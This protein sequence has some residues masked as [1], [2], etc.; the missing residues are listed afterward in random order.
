MLR[1]SG[2][3]QRQLLKCTDDVIYGSLQRLQKQID[4]FESAWKDVQNAYASLSATV[5]KSEELV[6]QLNNSTTALRAAAQQVREYLD[7]STKKKTPLAEMA[8]LHFGSLM[9][10]IPQLL[11][12][13]RANN[14][15]QAWKSM[16]NA[17]VGFWDRIL[18][19]DRLKDLYRTIRDDFEAYTGA[20]TGQ[21]RLKY[22]KVLFSLLEDQT[23][24]HQPIKTPQDLMELTESDLRV[25]LNAEVSTLSADTMRAYIHGNFTKY[26]QD[27]DLVRWL[28]QL[29]VELMKSVDDFRKDMEC[30]LLGNEIS[31]DFYR[32]VHSSGKQH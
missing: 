31:A 24:V 5:K 25:R 1:Q 14:N 28:G 4:D 2:D 20:R 12:D 30:F 27:C 7:H 19:D 11:R 17:A 23:G 16:E 9:K 21:E 18:Q 22:A 3:Y 29:E 8:V 10:M 26:A 32:F 15:S 6:V 13:V